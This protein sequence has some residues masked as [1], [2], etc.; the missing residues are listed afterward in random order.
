MRK[1]LYIETSVWNQLEHDDRPE[2]RE[3]SDKFFKIVSAGIYEP[4]ISNIVIDEISVTPDK[5]R[6]QR[7]VDHINRYQPVILDMNSEAEALARQYLAAMYVSNTPLRVY[8]DCAQVALATIYN[9]RHIVSF[10]FTHLVNDR[11]IDGFN[12]INIRNG[13]DLVVDITTPHRFLLETE[14]ED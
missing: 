14:Q 4:Y 12:A 13:Y 3:T 8:R 2:W 10:N 7:L 11:K 9:I 6:F 5:V 1:K